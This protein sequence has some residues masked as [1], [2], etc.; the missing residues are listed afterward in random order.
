MSNGH[1]CC[2]VGLC[3]PPGSAEQ[4]VALTEEIQKHHRCSRAKA[5]AAATA[6]LVAHN[7]FRDVAGLVSAA[8]I[9]PQ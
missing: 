8:S 2:I 7:Y 9:A 4:L 5:E 6:I 1:V 3:C